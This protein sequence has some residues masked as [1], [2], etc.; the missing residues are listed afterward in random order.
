MADT[1][2]ESPP[3]RVPLCI[4]TGFLGAGKTTVLNRVLGFQHH[5]RV[6]VIVNELGRIDIDGKLLKARAGDV[7][8]LTGGCVCHEVRTLE[9]LS[10]AFA[11]VM[12]R[13]RPEWIVLETT[14]IAQPQAILDGL[15]ALPAD[16]QRVQV[17][18]VI[19]VVD[20][21]AGVGQLE[22][23]SEARDQVACADGILLSKLDVAPADGLA[24]LH[25]A[26]AVLNPS[27][28]R[29]S[30]PAT[31][32]GTAALVPWLFDRA[33]SLRAEVV[34]GRSRAAPAPHR[35][36]QLTAHAFSHDAPFVA[37]ALLALAERLG[38]RI[39]RAKGFVDVAGEARRGFLERAG[40]RL[41]LRYLDAWPPG[42]RR[43]E[44]VFIGEDL[45]PAALER[46]LWACRAAGE[47]RG[48]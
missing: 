43:T 37:D 45:D 7:V 34:S 6:A 17:A 29:A 19:T 13:S 31:S 38:P 42:P 4:L 39:V 16:Q 48:R 40:T 9:E 10:E 21:E 1:S 12:A 15:A 18:A 33:P 32:H 35:H 23:F 26:L 30:F 8:E 41:E 3:P 24:A 11:E 27:A 47:D 46:Q 2:P 14:G 36:G 22:R 20:G 5:R 44:L 25:R 28:E